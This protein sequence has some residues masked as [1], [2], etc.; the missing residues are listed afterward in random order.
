MRQAYRTS[1]AAY[2]VGIWVDTYVQGTHEPE[3]RYRARSQA[4]RSAPRVS[5]R[6]IQ[7]QLGQ[8]G[9]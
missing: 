7:N 9:P 2:A 1:V 4:V 3:N 5:G 8:D 6:P